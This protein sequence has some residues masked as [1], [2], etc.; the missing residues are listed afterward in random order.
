MNN[1]E[2]L[3]LIEKYENKIRNLNWH[4][5]FYTKNRQEY[6]GDISRELIED[7]DLIRIYQARI[8]ELKNI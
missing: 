4:I 1:L 3:D 8:V 2:R 6:I 7:N 5:Q